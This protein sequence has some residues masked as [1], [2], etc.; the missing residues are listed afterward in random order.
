MCL[1][2]QGKNWEVKCLS[3][4]SAETQ[5]VAFNTTLGRHGL[6]KCPLSCLR[7]QD[8]HNPFSQR[9]SIASPPAPSQGAPDPAPGH[10][11]PTSGVNVRLHRARSFPFPSITFLRLGTQGLSGARIAHSCPAAHSGFLKPPGHNLKYF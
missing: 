11:E 1:Q 6:Q 9:P 2:L 8:P 3:P 7:Y 10:I 5:G 4:S